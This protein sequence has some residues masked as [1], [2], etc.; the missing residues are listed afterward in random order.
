MPFAKLDDQVTVLISPTS[1]P[2]HSGLFTWLCVHARSLQSCLTLCDPVDCSL[3]A[4]SVQGILQARIL[5]WVAMPSSRSPW[6]KES[7]LCPLHLL[8]WQAG[9][10]PLEPPRSLLLGFRSTHFLC[11]PP[12]LLGCYFLLLSSYCFMTIT[13]S[14][15][16]LSS[17]WLLSTALPSDCFSFLFIFMQMNGLKYHL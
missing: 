9:S 7:N 14:V 8:H 1:S 17:P 6:P 16:S 11:F 5:E 2:W 10:L 4:S 3:P 12:A 15:S 13:S